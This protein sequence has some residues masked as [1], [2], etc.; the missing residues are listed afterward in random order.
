MLVLKKTSSGLD[1]WTTLGTNLMVTRER[2]DLLV[3]RMDDITADVQTGKG[4]VGKLLTGPTTADELQ[5][6]LNNLQQASTNL[7]AIEPCH[8][9]GS[10]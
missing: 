8:R 3:E 5:V 10:Q 1:T 7:P 6:T 2:L 4:T 9:P